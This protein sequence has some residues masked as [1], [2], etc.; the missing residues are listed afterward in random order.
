MSIEHHSL[1][2]EFP[3]HSETI[4]QLK[5]ENAHFQRLMGEHEAIDKEIVRMEENIETPEDSVLTEKKKTRLMLK[6]E[7]LA[8]IVKAEGQQAFGP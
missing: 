6:D 5:Q 4:H 2:A 7:L 3:E 8:M 1:A